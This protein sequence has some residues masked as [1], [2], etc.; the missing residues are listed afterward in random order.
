MKKNCTYI[1]T[2]C[3]GFVGNVLTKKLL[4]EGCDVVGLA[5][6]ERKAETV[7]GAKKPRLIYGDVT[8]FET[9]AAL[10]NGDGP[11]IVIHT[12][13]KVTIGEGSEK[14]LYDVTV[15]GTRNV[16]DACCTHNA[17]LLHISSTEALPRGVSLK[18]DLSNYRPD[19]L[20]SRK[21]YPRVKAEADAEVF[22]AV[23]ERGLDASVL[24][25]ASVIGPGDYGNGHMAQ[26]FIDF[27]E[28]RLPASVRAGYNDF[29]IRDVAN[30]LPAI[31]ERAAKGESYIFANRPDR[32]DEILGYAAEHTGKKPLPA[33]PL[34]TAYLGLPFLYLYAKLRRK[35][36]LYT[37]AALAALRENTDFPLRKT[38]ET[39][40]FSPR[41]LRQTVADEIDFL[42]QTG[43]AKP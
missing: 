3:T 9:V 8:N 37:R 2:G 24:L 32:I 40:G 34:W 36:P 28:G 4:N 1:V 10:F 43:K 12:V 38:K 22:R 29:D 6:S 41:P 33:L 19:P 5:R 7:F 35:R 14:E 30:V 39:F 18:E 23:R 25:F 20:R 31:V 11:F 16:I 17:K 13:A 26:M 42:I 27:L 21:G 15:G